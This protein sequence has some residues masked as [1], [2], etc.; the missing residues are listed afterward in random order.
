MPPVEHLVI[1]AAGRG[2]R[3]GAGMPKCLVPVNG[4]P[5]INYQL[6]LARQIPS[7]RIVVGYCEDDV[8]RHILSIRKDVIFVR[9]PNYRHTTTLQSL[10]LA[11]KNMREPAL[12]MDGDMIIEENS[13]TAFLDECGKGLPLIGVS[14]EISDDP[15][16]A[17]T[18]F[19]G[20]E[21]RVDNFERGVPTAHEWANLAFIPASWL[22]FEPVNFYDRLLAFL[23]LNARSVKRIEIDTPADLRN[24]NDL[25]KNNPAYCGYEMSDA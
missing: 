22:T 9:N 17:Q 12:F 7:V 14:S 24:A 18:C 5:V 10:A 16:Y 20:Q 15:V 4:I 8:I 13:F 21:M 25:L 6:Y 19:S 1:A 23:P 11:V 3:L 2:K